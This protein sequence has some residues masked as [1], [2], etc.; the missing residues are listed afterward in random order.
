MEEKNI[1]RASLPVH[2]R[3]QIYSNSNLRSRYPARG[4]YVHEC[5]RF[6]GDFAVK[7]VPNNVKKSPSNSLFDK[8]LFYM[9]VSRGTDYHNLFAFGSPLNF[10]P[11]S[12][13]T[14]VRLF[15]LPLRFQIGRKHGQRYLS[16][17]SYRLL[18][19]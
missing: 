9:N 12:R 13:G 8:Q 11:T 2:V 14:Y 6:E 17:G 15:D 4:R 19:P 16:S 5:C 18:R 10:P 3:I 7:E 1:P